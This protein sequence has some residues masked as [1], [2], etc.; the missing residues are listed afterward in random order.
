MLDNFHNTAKGDH[1]MGM[2]KIDSFTLIRG[3]KLNKQQTNK[4]FQ[5]AVFCTKAQC[6]AP[7]RKHTK[8][9]GQNSG[10]RKALK[11][12]GKGTRREALLGG[13]K[14]EWYQG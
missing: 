3:T 10:G 1:F 4:L 6:L 9:N 8:G 14:I 2:A 5:L 13:D 11:S 12:R 7:H